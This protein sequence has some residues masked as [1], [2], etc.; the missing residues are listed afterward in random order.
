M[1]SYKH[2]YHAGNHSDTLKH[3]CLI[4]FLKSV[5]KQDN[6]I[7]Y[8]D[9]HAGGSIYDF[10]HEYMQKNKEFLTG[11]SKLIKFKTDDPYLRLYIKTIKNINKTSKITFYP[12]SPKIINFLTDKKDELYFCELHSNEY[13]ELKKNFSKFGNIKI[14]NK[15]GFSVFDNIIINKKKKGIILVDP[16]YEIKDDYEKVIALINKNYNIFQNKIVIVWYPVLNRNDTDNFINEFKRTGIKEILRIEMPIENDKEEK[17]MT[18][19]GLIILNTHKKT[20]QSLR[21]TISELQNCLQIK[22]NKKKIIVNYLR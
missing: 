12:G 6:S 18:G 16:S 21:G 14:I 1:L 19:S 13:R 2:G 22:G 7:T 11:I 17:G 8:I 15:D 5:K 10:K 20:A 3:I 9:T 4:Y